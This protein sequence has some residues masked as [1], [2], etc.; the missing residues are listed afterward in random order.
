MLYITNNQDVFPALRT[1]VHDRA[2]DGGRFMPYQ[3][4]RMTQKELDCITGSGYGHAMAEILNLFFGSHLTRTDVDFLIGRKSFRLVPMSHRIIF[5]EIWRNSEWSFDYPVRMISNQILG[6]EAI[7]GHST[8]WA[9]Q[10]IRIGAV[11][12]IFAQMRQA[13]V[14]DPG[15]PMD[16]AVDAG[17]FSA[18]MSVLYARELGLPINMVICGCGENSA[19]WELFCQGEFRGRAT[20]PQEPDWMEHLIRR[21]LGSAE[22]EKFSSVCRRGGVYCPDALKLQVLQNGITAAVIG[23]NRVESIIPNVYRTNSY[24]LGPETAVAYGGLQDYRAL[25]NETSPALIL[26]EFCP[27]KH[28]QEVSSLLGICPEQIKTIL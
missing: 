14:W 13:G 4:G 20:H 24:L 18:P 21:R 17:D 10:A 9:Y 1:L 23:R 7:S 5:G 3:L 6:D 12:G 16:V 27:L 11:F 28:A 25:N 8:E 19:P 15:Q 22:A 2:P 26:S